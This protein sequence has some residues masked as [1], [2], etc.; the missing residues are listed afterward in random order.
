MIEELD[1]V[2]EAFVNHPDT[3]YMIRNNLFLD[4]D[5]T[6][7][8][9]RSVLR[10][11]QNRAHHAFRRDV[12]GE[13]LRN[14]QGR[15]PYEWYERE[16]EIL[17]RSKNRS[18]IRLVGTTSNIITPFNS[19]SR[20]VIADRTRSKRGAIDDIDFQRF[21]KF[22]MWGP[23]DIEYG[24]YDESL[25]SDIN[26]GRTPHIERAQPPNGAIAYDTRRLFGP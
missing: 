18:Q 10:V 24:P 25:L 15:G 3:P 2:L 12:Q 13:Q 14:F 11:A 26:F 4:I 21:T 23:D 7:V 5:R 19:P 20:D 16:W 1:S 6:I 9:T 8:N 17:N 22:Q